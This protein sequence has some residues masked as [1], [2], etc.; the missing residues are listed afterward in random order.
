M[1]GDLTGRVYTSRYQNRAGLAALGGA[2][3]R[4]TLG[5]PRFNLGYPLDLHIPAFAPNR[6]TF[7]LPN[8][9]ELYAAQLALL[10]PER[11]LALLRAAHAQASTAIVLMCFKDVLAGQDCHRRHLAAWLARETGLVVPELDGA[12]EREFLDT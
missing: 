8:W 7:H 1:T 11:A 5:R 6:V 10:G 3:V 12:G 4:I 2:A 9:A